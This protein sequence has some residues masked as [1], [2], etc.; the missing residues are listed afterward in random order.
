MLRL[1][2]LS[3]AVEPLYEMK[4]MV[5]SIYGMQMWKAKTNEFIIL[6]AHQLNYYV[7]FIHPPRTVAVAVVAASSALCILKQYSRMLSRTLVNIKWVLF[8]DP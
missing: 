6:F 4:S 1:K 8:P 2:N 5:G 7:I 3:A